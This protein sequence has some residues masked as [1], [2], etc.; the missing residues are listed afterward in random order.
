MLS[1]DDKHIL[2][3]SIID[4]LFKVVVDITKMYPEDFSDEQLYN[5]EKWIGEITQ[6]IAIKEYKS[7][8][9]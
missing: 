8:M 9:G 4:E 7:K 5:I 3:Q 6:T 1:I 2:R